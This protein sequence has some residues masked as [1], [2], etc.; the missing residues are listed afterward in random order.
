VFIAVILFIGVYLLGL[1]LTGNVHAV[2]PNQVYRSAQLSFSHYENIVERKHIKTIIDLAPTYQRI[3]E[4]YWARRHHVV[5]DYLPLEAKGRCPINKLKILTKELMRAKTPLL[6]HCKSGSDRTGLAAAVS[7]ILHNAPINEIKNQIAYVRY[8]ILSPYSI[9]RVTLEPY[10]Q[11]LKQHH[12]Q[13]N[14]SHYL[15]W[16]NQ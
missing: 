2:I 12:W 1:K 3:K 6:V 16:I 10:F 13:S 14:R 8:G 7:L 11:W 15:V 9:G 5:Y 4:Y